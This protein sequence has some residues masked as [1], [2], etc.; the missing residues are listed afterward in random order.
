MH[1]K[2]V[3]DYLMDTDPQKPIHGDSRGYVGDGTEDWI[4]QGLTSP[5]E[6]TSVSPI[7]TDGSDDAPTNLAEKFHA[8]FIQ[9]LKEIGEDSTYT[10][11]ANRQFKL[12]REMAEAN[13]EEEREEIWERYEFFAKNN[14]EQIEITNSLRQHF[15]DARR[16]R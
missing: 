16:T 7:T 3:W 9:Y 13:S 12:E 4:T 2:T 6:E 15:T 8:N 14:A 1:P 10:T 5:I 11:I